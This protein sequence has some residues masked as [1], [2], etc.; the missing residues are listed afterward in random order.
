MAKKLSPIAD[1]RWQA[2]CDMRTLAEAD[3]I[4]SDPKRLAAAKREA[5][6]QVTQAQ[7]IAKK[8]NNL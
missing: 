4:S 1:D 7:R 2:E 5:R 6:K 3:K 8:L